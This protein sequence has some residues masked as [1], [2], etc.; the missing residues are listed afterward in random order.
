M[1]FKK[2]RTDRAA[3]RARPRRLIFEPLED[4][5]LLSVSAAQQQFVYLLNRARHDPLA[6]Q[7]EAGLA[8]DLSAVAPRP[9][10]AVNAALMQAAAEHAQEMATLDYVD[11]QSPATGV[12]S[13]QAAR[14]AGYE[15]PLAWPDDGNLIESIAAGT[16]YPQADLSLDA[17]IVDQGVSNAAHRS[18]LLGI[19]PFYAENREIGVGLATRA[20]STYVNYWSVYIARREPTDVFLTGVVFDDLDGN[21]RYDAGEGLPD[22]IVQTLER[23]TTSNAAGGFSL[24]VPA[25][26]RYRV[27]ASG[28]SLAA[29]VSGSVAVGRDN[30]ELDIISGQRGMFTDFST[31]PTSGWTNPEQRL[32]VSDDRV[33]D[34]RDALQVINHLNDAGA[35]ALPDVSGWPAPRLPLLDVDGDGYVLPHDALYIINHLNQPG[36]AAVGGVNGASEYVRPTRPANAGDA[37]LTP[38]PLVPPTAMPSAPVAAGPLAPMTSRARLIPVRVFAAASLPDP[39]AQ[40]M[41]IELQRTKSASRPQAAYAWREHEDLLTGGFKERDE[42]SADAVERI[43]ELSAAP[44]TVARCAHSNSARGVIR[45]L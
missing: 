14:N 41:R 21:G 7:R 30:V 12:W 22:I 4:R 15:L 9:P 37:P 42:V 8:V 2:T 1:S 43:H 13:N 23:A 35:G 19:A 28:P 25:D 31:M 45:R 18:H 39:A 5:R 38:E 6:Y 11:H 34:A 24:A 44:A 27:L 40:T 3:A 36:G 29:P 17:L 33:V 20:D 26:G 16:R 10:L 32:D